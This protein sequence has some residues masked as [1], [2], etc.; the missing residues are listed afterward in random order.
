MFIRTE[1]SE[2]TIMAFHYYDNYLLGTTGS[3]VASSSQGGVS[4]DNMQTNALDILQKKSKKSQSLGLSQ[5]CSSSAAQ[6]VKNKK[7]PKST[8]RKLLLLKDDVNRLM[9]SNK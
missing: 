4:P 3:S 1:Y 2:Y 5:D 6:R 7:I 8:K 9:F